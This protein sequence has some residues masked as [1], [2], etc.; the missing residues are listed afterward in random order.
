MDGLK[1]LTNALSNGT[2]PDPLLP[3]LPQFLGVTTPPNTAIAI[4]SGTGE[5]MDFKFGR[6]IHRVHP[7]Q[8]PLK[9]LE[10]GERG[11]IQRLPNILKYPPIISGT[12]TATDFKFGRSI[13]RVH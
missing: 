11:R 5:A 9:I 3:P 2:I 4:I 8:S 13:H 7:N 1:E 10:K 12:G 6:H